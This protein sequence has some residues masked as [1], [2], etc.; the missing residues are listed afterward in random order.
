MSKTSRNGKR[1]YAVF[2]TIELLEKAHIPFNIKRS[3]SDALTIVAAIV[4]ERIEIDV[5]EDDHVEITRFRS[6]ESIEGGRELLVEIVTAELRE[7]FPEEL[8]DIAVK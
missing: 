1:R 5:F 8:S 4:G 7:N 2:D 3:R 6:D